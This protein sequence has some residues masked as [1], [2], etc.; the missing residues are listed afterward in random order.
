MTYGHF[1]FYLYIVL[2]LSDL[3]NSRVNGGFMEETGYNIT[4]VLFNFYW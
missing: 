4:Q 2:G 3:Y 1:N